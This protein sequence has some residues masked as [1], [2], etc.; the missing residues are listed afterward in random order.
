[1][2]IARC[3][4]EGLEG[5]GTRLSP[6]PA[7]LGG[8]FLVPNPS[9][10]APVSCERLC[11]PGGHGHG[12]AVLQKLLHP[13]Q[14][15]FGRGREHLF[16]KPLLLLVLPQLW[17]KE[18]PSTAS[19]VSITFHKYYARKGTCQVSHILICFFP[20]HSWIDGLVQSGCCLPYRCK[21]PSRGP[22]HTMSFVVSLE[23]ADVLFPEKNPPKEGV[24]YWIFFRN[25][26]FE[27]W[28]GDLSVQ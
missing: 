27:S 20:M 9:Q 1:M 3:P 25:L 13:R 2:L 10:I 19:A 7:C 12:W 8:G 24:L 5:P 15:P 4:A 14:S 26:S 18:Q 11:Q 21:A 28:Q 6:S 17:N 22:L 16:W 23:E